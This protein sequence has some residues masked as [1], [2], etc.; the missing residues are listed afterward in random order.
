MPPSWRPQL[1]AIKKIAPAV[2]AGNSV[3]VKPS[4]LAP[5]TVLNFAKI[6]TEAGLPDGVLNVV[7][8]FGATAGKRLSE[9]PDIKKLDLTGGTP[10]G[11]IV[12][13]SAGKN[14]ASVVA[15]LGGKAPMVVRACHSRTDWGVASACARALRAAC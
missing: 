2:A 11:R 13:A 4:E 1:I 15:E 8:G 9:H 12:A 14:L 7:P 3:V 10:T 6:C 5:V